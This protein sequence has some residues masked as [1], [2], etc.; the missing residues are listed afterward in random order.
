MCNTF[1]RG[2]IQNLAWKGLTLYWCGNLF[3]VKCRHRRPTAK[4]NNWHACLNFAL[5]LSILTRLLI[6]IQPYFDLLCVNYTA[7][8]IPINTLSRLWRAYRRHNLI[9]NAVSWVSNACGSRQRFRAICPWSCSSMTSWLYD[10]S[11]RK[12]EESKNYFSERM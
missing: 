6:N 3:A 1:T 7:R 4:F 5:I 8:S 11:K 10:T 12:P 2:I 9:E